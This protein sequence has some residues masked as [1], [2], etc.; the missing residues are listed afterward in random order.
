MSK[1]C[2]ERSET[3]PERGSSANEVSLRGSTRE[4][5]PRR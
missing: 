4:G 3:L 2:V 5:K 1:A